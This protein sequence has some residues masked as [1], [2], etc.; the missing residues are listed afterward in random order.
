MYETPPPTK[1]MTR[2]GIGPRWVR[3]CVVCLSPFIVAGAIWPNAFAMEIMPRN[4]LRIAGI[5]LLTAG[6]PFGVAALVTLHRG[7]VRGE[8]FTRGVYGLCRH[9]IYA[10]WIVFLVPGILLLA[11]S[12]MFLLAPLVM[13]V[14]LRLMIRDE[15]A[16]LEATFQDEYRAYRRRVPAVLPVPRFWLS[17]NKQ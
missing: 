11:G 14:L 4:V 10:S 13:Y 7:F 17:R 1:R 15:E 12:W 8:L 2:W 6:I 9:P 3:A 5:L 16:F